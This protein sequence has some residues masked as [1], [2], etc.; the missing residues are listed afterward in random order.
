[1]QQRAEQDRHASRPVGDLLPRR[2]I[3]SATIFER[4]QELLHVILVKGGDAHIVEDPPE[5][6]GL[7]LLGIAQIEQRQP[8]AGDQ[9]EAVPLR[10]SAQLV[11]QVSR[12]PG[13]CKRVI[14]SVEHHEQARFFLFQFVKYIVKF[15]IYLIIF[16][17]DALRNIRTI[18]GHQLRPD[19][20][21]K[22]LQEL[23]IR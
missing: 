21:R 17:L 5:I 2:L 9:P 14:E 6:R 18:S 12:Q 23:L 7:R 15:H 1:M 22:A 11:P 16:E 3:E 8:A 10:Q 20:L 19:F 4:L 13:A